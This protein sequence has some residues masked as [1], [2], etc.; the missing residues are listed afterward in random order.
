[1]QWRRTSALDC[2]S[3]LL[4][5]F[6]TASPWLFAYASERA[7]IDIW[8]SGAA[9]TLL[10][11]AAVVIFAVWEEWLNLALGLWLMASPFV[12]DFVH[13]RAMHVTIG[14]GAVVTFLAAL[15]LWLVRFEPHYGEP[16][17]DPGPAGSPRS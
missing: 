3:G 13:T 15:E 16:H 1:M 8:V 6:L 7:R 11:I 9:I 5:I 12:L 4:G 10:S 17:R 14:L 2:Y